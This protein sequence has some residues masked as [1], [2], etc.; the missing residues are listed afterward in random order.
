MNKKINKKISI[1]FKIT[2]AVLAYGFIVYHLKNYRL[3]DFIVDDIFSVNKIF[4]LTFC[5]VLM[6][7]NWLIETV[8]W[9]F[10]IRNIEKIQ[11]KSAFIAVLTGV[12]FAIFTPNRI[13][14]L[15]GRIFVLNR[16]NRVKGVMATAAGSL[17]QLFVTLFF[18]LISGLF[19]L[20]LFP[21]RI[22]NINGNYLILTE[23]IVVIS[24]ILVSFLFFNLK[25]VVKIALRIKFMKKISNSLNILSDY[26]IFDLL[27]LLL[28][29]SGRYFVF[30]FQFYLL[31]LFFNI[32]ISL[33]QAFMTISLTYLLNSV[34]PSFTLSEIGVRGS[35]AMFFI[36]MFSEN[37][38]GI[39][40]ASVLL[41]IINLA[42]PAFAGSILFY[43]TKIY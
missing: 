39:L 8:K 16:R 11:F 3:S 9:Q 42:I 29:S 28:F 23:I 41:W 15:G 31:L 19:L 37:S 6:P 21:Q 2:I 26:S 20:L 38:P 17:S 7:V 40:S 35:A 24:V 10:L 14:E 22:A 12:S 1:L 5:I 30:L 25:K 34:I 4:L 33:L 32:E 36:G 27:K 18:G 13:G 43:R